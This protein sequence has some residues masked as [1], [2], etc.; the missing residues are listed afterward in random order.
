[1]H[2]IDLSNE[3]KDISDEHSI[4]SI[5]LMLLIK[6]G[7]CCSVEFIERIPCSIHCPVGGF[8]LKIQYNSEFGIK[9]ISKMV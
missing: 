4:E 3:I 7:P 1:M 5:V 9:Y 6:Y 2:V 8:Q